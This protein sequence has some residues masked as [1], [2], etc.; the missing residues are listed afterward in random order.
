MKK[1]LLPAALCFLSNIALADHITVSD[2]WARATPPGAQT[3]AIYLTLTNQGAA[4][5]LVA[6]GTDAARAAQLHTHLHADGMMRMEQI[7]ALEL[8]ANGTAVMAP[9]GDHVMLIGLQ[10]P[11]VPGATATLTRE[12]AQHEALSVSIPVRDGRR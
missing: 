2:A 10:Q 4:D 11:L 6:L 3:G 12:F 7:A 1:R 8:P 5:R 9:G